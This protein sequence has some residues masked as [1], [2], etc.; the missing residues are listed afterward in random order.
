MEVYDIQKIQ[1]ASSWD[2]SALESLLQSQGLRLDHDVETAFGVYE[3][4]GEEPKLVGCGCA[5]GALL[6]C[7]ALLPQL[8]GQNLPGTAC[9]WRPAPMTAS[10]ASGSRP[11]PRGPRTR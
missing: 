9:W 4:S 8:R 5:A 11:A 7:F 10:G 3:T 6:K 2:R 1:L